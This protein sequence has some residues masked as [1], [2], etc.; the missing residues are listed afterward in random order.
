MTKALY[1]QAIIKVTFGVVL[2]GAL[3]FLPA[4]TFAFLNGWFCPVG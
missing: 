4:G 3:I 2:V 1:F